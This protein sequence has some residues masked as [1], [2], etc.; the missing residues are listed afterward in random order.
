MKTA[1]RLAA[2][3]AVTLLVAHAHAA[4]TTYTSSATFLAAV[5][6]GAYTETFDGLVDPFLVAP[7]TF[8]NGVFTY[9]ITAPGGTYASGTDIGTSQVEVAL[10]ITFSGKP[11][12]AVGGNFYATDIN[13]DF[14]PETITV[15]LID[16]AGTTHTYTP[17]SKA[18][19]L[20]FTSTTGIG[21]LTIDFAA[22]YYGRYA[23]VDNL[24]VGTNAALVPEPGQWALMAAGLAGLALLRRRQA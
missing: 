7:D 19:F 15:S 23:T 11:V 1:Y 9:S 14:L 6:H 2:T 13:P 4:T 22:P 18:T 10:T 21:S 24:T 20:G 16:G 5:T 8:T 12:T 3:A 17:S